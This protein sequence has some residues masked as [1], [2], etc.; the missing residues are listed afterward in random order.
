[1]G[2]LLETIYDVLFNP[3]AAMETIAQK[4]LTGQALVMFTV[5]M[6][7]PVW[8]VY[9][10]IK[11]APALGSMFVLHFIGSL[12]FWVVGASVL[13]FVA[14]LAGGHGTAVGLF[15]ALGFSHLPRVA[16]IPLGVI[17][18]LLPDNLR[19]IAFGFIGLL[20]V[21][22]TL[23]LSV[24][25][26]R[27]AHGLSGAKAVLVLLAPLLAMIGAIIAAVIFFGAALLEFPLHF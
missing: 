26:I 27:G 25:A 21:I 24:A 19:G 23:S 15:A 14:E 9:T 17:A 16:V 8:A 20:V 1:M 2:N 12:F 13:N 10:G 3:R 7:V 5:G 18:A 4:K 11:G 22:W 6:L